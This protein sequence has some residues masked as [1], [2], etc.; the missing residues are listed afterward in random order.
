MAIPSKEDA[1]D[2]EGATDV[3]CERDHEQNQFIQSSEKEA[4][5]DVPTDQDT[6]TQN[7]CDSLSTR[8]FPYGFKTSSVVSYGRCGR[9]ILQFPWFNDLFRLEYARTAVA[10]IYLIFTP[11]PG[12]LRHRLSHHV[13]SA[14]H[15]TIHFHIDAIRW[16][17]RR[18]GKTKRH[19]FGRII[20]QRRRHEFHVG[21][22]H[23]RGDVGQSGVGC[24]QQKKTGSHLSA[25]LSHRVGGRAALRG[26]VSQ[27]GSCPRSSQTRSRSHRTLQALHIRPSSYIT[28]HRLIY[29][30][31]EI[32]SDSASGPSRLFRGAFVQRF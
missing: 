8:F 5:P 9:S 24:W 2:K 17:A 16:E 32:P 28:A 31:H 4:V 12:T 26:A 19:R 1:T 21:V 13:V 14:Q 25:L 7:C 18:S 20:R 3:A 22:I 15:V 23:R 10:L 27:R 30:R 29:R 6:T 11:L